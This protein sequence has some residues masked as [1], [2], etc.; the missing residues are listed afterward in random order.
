MGRFK[1]CDYAQGMFIP[2]YLE[3]QLMP[4]TLEYAI[5]NLV[6]KHIDLSIFDGKYSNDETGRLAYDPKVLLKVVLLG[7]SRGLMTSRKIE[8]ACRDN[9]VF[10][11]LSCSQHPDHSTIADFVSSMGNEIL[12]LFRNILLVCEELGLLGGTFF[13][14]DGCKLPGNASKQWSGTIDNLKM[15]KDKIE[16]KV[17]EMIRQ[18][19]EGD[20]KDAPVKD[21][22]EKQVDKLNRQAERIGAWLKENEAKTNKKGKEVKSNITDNDSA[23]MTTAHGVILG[24]NSQALVDSK[25]QVIIHGEAFGEGQDAGL[26]PPM[27]DGAKANMVDE[28]YFAGK[29]LTADSGYHSN[30]NIH[31]CEEEKIDAYIPDKKFRMRDP[32]FENKRRMTRTFFSHK[33]FYHD[34]EKD[35][36]IC[37]N[38]RALSLIVKRHVS[39]N[40]A[41]RMYR[42]QDCS[43][44][45]LKARCI[46]GDGHGPKTLTIP[47]GPDGVN[48]SKM[49]VKKIE[50]E[51]GRKIYPQRMP[52][53]EPV[54]ANIR[55]IKRLDHFTLRGKIKVNIQW[56]LYCMVHNM[57][58]IANYGFAY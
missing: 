48:L 42:A 6:E 28:E 3:E 35:K 8:Q 45:P 50:S 47:L 21:N 13:A 12:P 4:G 1:R 14:L 57:E 58:K 16:E 41:Y 55:I 31:K 51:E 54:F 9:I 29:I 7:Y 15:K 46:Y 17:K 25:H 27:I 18:Q 32:R 56:L 23:L 33:D 52:I 49:M 2:V 53:V 20:R 34:K 22:L 11:A 26:I 39:E 40:T 10:M 38:G 30:F 36:Y 19:Q 37:P 43:G 24:Y 5:H 44:C